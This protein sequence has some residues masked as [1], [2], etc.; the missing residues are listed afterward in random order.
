MFAFFGKGLDMVIRT[1][2]TAQIQ[3]ILAS[4]EKAQARSLMRDLQAS[5]YAYHFAHSTDRKTLVADVKALIDRSKGS[6]PTVLVINSKFA[7]PCCETLLRVARDAAKV[8]AIE[9]VV[10]NPP[11][12]RGARARLARLGAR[13]FDGEVSEILAEPALH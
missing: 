7:G 8:M 2:E 11:P 3:L 6:L 4:G 12:G 1:S 9:C 5:R 13:L 10:T